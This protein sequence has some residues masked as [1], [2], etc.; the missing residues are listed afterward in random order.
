MMEKLFITVV[1]IICWVIVPIGGGWAVM[2][3]NKYSLVGVLVGA[4][5]TLFSMA[6]FWCMRGKD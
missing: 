5:L 4:F 6:C 2:E 3:Y 1:E